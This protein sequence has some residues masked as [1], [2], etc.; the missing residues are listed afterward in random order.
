M[1]Y[2]TRNQIHTINERGFPVGVREATTGREFLQPMVIGQGAG[3]W[4][5]TNTTAEITLAQC[6]IP[7]GLMGPAGAVEVSYL[8]GG[9]SSANTK[10]FRVRMANVV[11]MAVTATTNPTTRGYSEVFN[12]TETNQ[13]LTGTLHAASAYPGVSGTGNLATTIDTRSDVLVTLTVQL[14]LATETARLD[15]W[16]VIVYPT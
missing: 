15:H 1:G 4:S 16:R 9:T 12:T 8:F 3:P 14:A 5:T 2:D 6:V 7:G 13:L 10:T 11:T